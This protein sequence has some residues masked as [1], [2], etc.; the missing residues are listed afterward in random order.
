MSHLAELGWIC[1]PIS[2]CLA[3]RNRWPTQIVDVKRAIAWVRDNIEGY[4]GDPAFIC[5]TGGSAGGHLSSL[6]ALSVNDPAF[7]P[8]F[9]DADTSVRAEVPFYGAYDFTNRDKT[10]HTSLVPFIEKRVVGVPHAGNEGLYDAAS[11]MSRVHAD[12]PPFFAAVAAFLGH[13]WADYRAGI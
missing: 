2:Y 5:L 9:E 12:A 7:Q 6:A 3:P 10:G 4:G 1:V 11:P 13:V 8:D